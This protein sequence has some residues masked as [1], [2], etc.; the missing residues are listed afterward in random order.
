[1]CDS[2]LKNNNNLFCFSIFFFLPSI[3]FF[4]PQSAQY[5][6]SIHILGENWWVPFPENL[7]QSLMRLDLSPR[8]WL[9]FLLTCP[10]TEKVIF[11]NIAIIFVEL[12]NQCLQ[13]IERMRN[14]GRIK[15]ILVNKDPE[16]GEFLLLLL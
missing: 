15:L 1:M 2:M 10:N 3:F 14:R 8:K 9:L 6:S 11:S 7:L 4:L 12:C 16:P 13:I 5:H